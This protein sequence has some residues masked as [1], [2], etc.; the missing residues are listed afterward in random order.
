M[1]H[2]VKVNAK[3]KQARLSFAQLSPSLFN[4]LYLFIHLHILQLRQAPVQYFNFSE[5][6]PYLKILNIRNHKATPLLKWL[7]AVTRFLLEES[8]CQLLL[9]K[10]P[11]TVQLLE[12]SLNSHLQ[13]FNLSQ[14]CNTVWSCKDL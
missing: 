10:I 4:P 3:F 11:T 7:A 8:G 9:V 12:I 5:I 13:Y 1:K 2:N 6:L 14:E